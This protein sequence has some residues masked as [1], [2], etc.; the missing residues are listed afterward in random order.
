MSTS[1]RLAAALA[2]VAD[3]PRHARDI[4]RASR[5]W[6]WVAAIASV[7]VLGLLTWITTRW[8]ARRLHGKTR[9]G[10]RGLDRL[11]APLT[12]LVS[13]CAS[14]GILA[15]SD[16]EPPL[17][18]T[19]LEL[20][21]VIVGFWLA[22]RV[23]DVIWATGRHSA[24]LRSQPLAGSALLAGRHMGKLVLG[25]ATAAILAVRLGAGQQLYIVLAAIA[26]A[27]AFAARDPIRN[28]VAFA[29]MMIDPP[30]HLG[31]R[32]RFSD[33]RSGEDTVGEIIDI[34]LS[35][36]TL[37]TRAHTRVVIANVMVGQLRVE[38]LSTA[39]R[40]RIELAFPVANLSTEEIRSACAEIETDV[41][42]NPYVSKQQPP[43]V[44][45]AGMSDGLRL[46]VEVWLRR[47]A[48][49][50]EAQRE[51]VLAIRSRLAQL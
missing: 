32:V 34:S 50:R 28:G 22:S 13:V 41:S 26:A 1:H 7:L 35:G 18:T 23:L 17:V 11:T 36:V 33:F 39:D 19:T 14:L 43:R 37:R 44:W 49:W 31:D 21:V 30:F 16:R 10:L 5:V 8:V 25:G 38:N 2:P 47:A 46:E 20:L 9:Y 42:R 24:R 3:V 15:S 40:R 4:V 12:M 27:F 45:L 6:E 51:L 29:S 48:D